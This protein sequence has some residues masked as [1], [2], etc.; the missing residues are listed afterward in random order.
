M[1]AD[2]GQITLQATYFTDPDMAVW[3]AAWAAVWVA[4][5]GHGYRAVDAALHAAARAAVALMETAA[6]VATGAVI[7]EV[8]PIEPFAMSNPCR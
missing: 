2:C 6:M 3:A 7:D 1:P 8:C 5:C 4:A